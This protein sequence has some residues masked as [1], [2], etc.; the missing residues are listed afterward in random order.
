MIKASD[1]I[2]ATC[3][4]QAAEDSWKEGKIINVREYMQENYSKILNQIE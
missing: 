2:K 3:L 1:T 4:S